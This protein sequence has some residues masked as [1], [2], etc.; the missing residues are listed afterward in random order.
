MRC[1]TALVVQLLT[2]LPCFLSSGGLLDEEKLLVSDGQWH[3]NQRKRV[4]WETSCYYT[5]EPELPYGCQYIRSQL[6]QF[7]WKVDN[8]RGKEKG[9][10]VAFFNSAGGRFWRSSEN[11]GQETDPCWDSWYGVTCDE[12]GHVI[13]LEL[14]DNGLGGMLPE[15]GLSDLTFLL[16]LDLSSSQP[17]YHGYVN[18]WRNQIQGPIP[19]LATCIFLQELEISGNLFTSLPTDLYKN[20]GTLRV[21]SASHNLLTRLPERLEEFAALH[22]MELYNNQISG[23]LSSYAFGKLVNARFI[24]VQYNN[25]SGAINSDIIGMKKIKAF[26]VSHNPL[27]GG[28]LPRS[29]TVQWQDVDYISMLNTSLS[30]YVSSFCLDMP[31]CWK[32]MFD[33]HSDLTWATAADVPDI[34]NLTISLALSEK[35]L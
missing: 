11:W 3:R 1:V 35:G 16:K 4:P 26:D 9:A 10:L 30:G 31:L 23:N 34:V 17:D 19:S 5:S 20:A 8:I 6:P 24:H 28:E 12:H 2:Q 27:L 21:L 22:T 32:F 29:I 14:V 25:L 13:H 7:M 33:T 15:G 18:R